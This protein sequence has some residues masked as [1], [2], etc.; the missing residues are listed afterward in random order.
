MTPQS[1]VLMT[2]ALLILLGGFAGCG[3]VISPL[4]VDPAFVPATGLEPSRLTADQASAT[5][6]SYW[7][8][9]S[10]VS[11]VRFG[12][13]TPPGAV[14]ARPAWRVRLDGLGSSP[15]FV[16]IDDSTG[17]FLNARS[18]GSIPIPDRPSN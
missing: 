8:G 7:K 17:K 3:E 18:S 10:R 2:L 12:R 9:K 11:Q 5:A 15:I 1:K 4:D 6:Q 13:Y 16:V 14:E